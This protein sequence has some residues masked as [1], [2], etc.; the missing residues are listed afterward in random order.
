MKKTML[1]SSIL[2]LSLFLFSCNKSIDASDAKAD[3][4][5]VV[6]SLKDAPQ[7]EPKT[8]MAAN[9]TA[10]DLE[11]ETE[12]KQTQED[13]Q[14]IELENVKTTYESEQNN[15]NTPISKV[16][17]NQPIKPKEETKKP[18]DANV[19]A[20]NTTS[21]KSSEQA[22]V[23]K[24]SVVETKNQSEKPEKEE[25]IPT[26]ALNQ[27]FE[28]ANQFLNQS[29]SNGL[30]GYSSLKKSTILNELVE[31][32][33]SADLNDVGSAEKQ[34]FYINAYNILVIKSILENNIPSSPLDVLG[35]FDAKKHKVAGQTM[36]L[37]EL[38]KGRLFGLKKDP[39]FHFVAVCGA[40]GCPQ[41]EP[42]AYTPSKLNAQ[43]NRQTQKALNDPNFTRVNDAENKVELSE[44]F[45][46]YGSDFTQDGKSVIEFINEYRNQAIPT[47]YAVDYYPYDW[48]VNKR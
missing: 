19:L 31:Q 20:E 48:K 4:M 32:I 23:S 15:F 38:E 33:A 28:T 17:E 35:F 21:S 8:T 40:K 13:G 47:D 16:E 42:F 36:T 41:I 14:I 37:D 3:A 18:T 1:F 6:E 25:D 30:V 44:I 45:K 29:V 24:P 43:L 12:R 34:A 10:S 7:A 27:F 11:E 2:I 22:N 26:N 46:W 39:R 5:K 9:E